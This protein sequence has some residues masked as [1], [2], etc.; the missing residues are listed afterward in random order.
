MANSRKPERVID[1]LARTFVQQH[2][3][4]GY[5]RRQVID[6]L[7]YMASMWSGCIPAAAVAYRAMAQQMEQEEL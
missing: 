3:D 5:S 6:A 4:A 1:L 7:H 2:L